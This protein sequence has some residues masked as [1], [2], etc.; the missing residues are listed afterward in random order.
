MAIAY[1]I[2]TSFGFHS[3][4]IPLSLGERDF[5]EEFWLP[6]PFGRGAGGE[7]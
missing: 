4:A 1:R 3:T 2:R 7:G 6:S 5:Q